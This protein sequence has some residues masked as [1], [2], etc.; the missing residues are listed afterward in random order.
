MRKIITFL[1]LSFC[2]IGLFAQGRG[3]ISSNSS[4]AYVGDFKYLLGLSGIP[5]MDECDSSWWDEYDKIF[6]QDSKFA[7]LCAPTM[8][9]SFGSYDFDGKVT[10]PQMINYK[11]STYMVTCLNYSFWRCSK[12]TEVELPNSILEMYCAFYDCTSLKSIKIPPLVTVLLAG[13]FYNCSNLTSVELP[14]HLIRM[15]GS[16]GVFEKCDNILSVYC[17]NPVPP[18]CN[19]YD[20]STKCYRN[21]TLYV[22]DNSIN[23]YRNAT[24]W[25]NFV[26]IR[27]ISEYS[28][29]KEIRA[30][31]DADQQFDFLREIEIYNLFGQKIYHGLK[32]EFH[33]NNGLYIIKQGDLKAKILVK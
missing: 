20:F 5:Y 8:G 26:N 25:E 19:D 21:A 33:G 6:R 15:Q 31:S 28:A 18:E 3:I 29:I 12:M 13:T 7:T 17:P 2:S 1:F 4:Y 27:P 14:K 23:E 9:Q 30:D 22:P 32:S 24:C 10:V 11:M 16:A